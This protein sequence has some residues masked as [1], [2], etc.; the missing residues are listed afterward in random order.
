MMVMARLRK[1]ALMRGAAGGADLTVFVEVD[2]RVQPALDG[3][4]PRVMA[5]SWA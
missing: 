1:L 3:Q 4:W 5:A 2:V